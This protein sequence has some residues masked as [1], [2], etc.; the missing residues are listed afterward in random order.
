MTRVVCIRQWICYIVTVTSYG[1]DGVSNHQP[2]YFCSTVCLGADQRKHQSSASR[3]F[4]RGI[5]RWPINSPHKGQVTRK[6]L[7]FDDVIMFTYNASCIKHLRSYLI[8]AVSC[9]KIKRN[10]TSL[11]TNIYHFWQQTGVIPK[12]LYGKNDVCCH[13]RYVYL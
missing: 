13:E 7:P 11:T 12:H 6:M 1:R 10:I 4:V 2:H 3:A 9:G 8:H 5:H